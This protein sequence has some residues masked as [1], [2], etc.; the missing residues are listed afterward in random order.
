QLS[1]ELDANAE[2]GSSWPL[3]R[4]RLVIERVRNAAQWH[5]EMRPP[6]SG[7]SDILLYGLSKRWGGINCEGRRV[8]VLVAGTDGRGCGPDYR[9]A[10]IRYVLFIEKVENVK[11]K[12]QGN[13]LCQTYSM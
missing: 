11:R 1:L 6:V 9:A 13:V 5:A 7:V 3:E 12:T 10:T 4:Y 2:T 8:V